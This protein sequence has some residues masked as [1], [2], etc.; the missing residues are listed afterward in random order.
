MTVFLPGL[1]E[2]NQ[3]HIYDNVLDHN[4][5][6]NLLTNLCYHYEILEMSFKNSFLLII[7]PDDEIQR[8]KIQKVMSKK[9]RDTA[10]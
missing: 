10:S 1:Q 9:K 2:Y 5:G 8:R 3:F 7:C 4:G 6:S